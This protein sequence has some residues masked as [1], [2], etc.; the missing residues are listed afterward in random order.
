MQLTQRLQAVY[1]VTAAIECM[2]Q[3]FEAI[4]KVQSIVVV[5]RLIR[6]IREKTSNKAKRGINNTIIRT[7]LNSV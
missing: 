1:V 4:F 7:L 5:Q 3:S 2:L 6:R